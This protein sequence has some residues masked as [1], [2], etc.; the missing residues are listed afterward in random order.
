MTENMTTT[1][2]TEE[3]PLPCFVRHEDAGGQCY[4][5]A[6]MRVHG[7]NFCQLHGEETRTGA[8]LEEYQE[9]YD[10]LERFRNSEVPG[11]STPVDRALEAALERLHTEPCADRAHWE[12]L[13]RAYP[14]SPEDVRAEV[15]EWKEDEDPNH[16]GVL[17][18]LLGDLHLL[19]RLQ[20]IARE[21]WKTWL[22]EKL[23]YERQSRAA[24]A[25]VALKNANRRIAKRAK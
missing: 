21:D 14:D 1:T 18:E 17:D 2:T 8:A 19:H 13:L 4:R 23:E 11:V 25:A 22:V 9:V 24:R 5:P 10:F 16:A 20:R 6:A 15:R 7:L 12:A 3:Q